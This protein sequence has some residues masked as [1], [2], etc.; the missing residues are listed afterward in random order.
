MK[1]HPT[2][3]L[4]PLV[5]LMF[6]CQ[7][8]PYQQGEILYANFCANCHGVDG[9][10]LQGLIPPLAMFSER[11]LRAMMTAAGFEIVEDWQATKRAALFLIARVAD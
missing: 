7:S 6:Q 11:E 3:W 2:V 9:Q 8:N 5:A 1:I 10:G 4:A